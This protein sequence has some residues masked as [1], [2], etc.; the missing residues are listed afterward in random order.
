MAGGVRG[1]GSPIAAA[2]RDSPGYAARLGILRNGFAPY[3][4]AVPKNDQRSLFEVRQAEVRWYCE[5]LMTG[6]YPSADDRQKLYDQYQNLAEDATD[7]L[8]TQ[9]PFLDPNVVQTAKADYLSECYRNIEAP[10][11]P[12]FQRPFSEQQAAQAEERWH[13]LRYARVDLWR[14]LGGGR[15]QSGVKGDAPSARRILV[16]C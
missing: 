14:Q 6:P 9:F 10:L 12:I 11:L 4:E 3:W 8:V 1:D 16:T 15:Q 7:A 2:H 13:G 5:N